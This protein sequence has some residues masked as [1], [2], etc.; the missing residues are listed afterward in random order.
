MT[1]APT[2]IEQAMMRLRSSEW[3]ATRATMR[4]ERAGPPNRRL[5]PA[6]VAAQRAIDRRHRKAL[7]WRARLAL[8]VQDARVWWARRRA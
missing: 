6:L 3:D 4:G 5:D 7:G 1:T 2:E 8:L